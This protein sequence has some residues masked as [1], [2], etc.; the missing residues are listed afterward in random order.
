MN[1]NNKHIEKFILLGYTPK[2]NRTVEKNLMLSGN[3]CCFLSSIILIVYN[4]MAFINDEPFSPYY[5]NISVLFL[6]PIVVAG[7]IFFC[8]GILKSLQKE[9]KN[10]SPEN[11][12]I[13]IAS[14]I[15]VM[16]GMLFARSFFPNVSQSIGIIVFSIIIILLILFCVF[17][18]S[19]DY[20]KVYLIRKYCP[21]LKKRIK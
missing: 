11:T 6:T 14:S 20:Y 1:S 18:A 7:S 13:S 2:K 12:Y 15:A 17:V 5:T 9:T 8:R 21:Y 16:M 19:V 10:T 4:I 3:W